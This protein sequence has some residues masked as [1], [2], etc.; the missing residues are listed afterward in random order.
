MT[1]L[2]SMTPLAW[3]KMDTIKRIICILPSSICCLR[4]NMS[5]DIHTTT[6]NRLSICAHTK[7]GWGPYGRT[8]V[9]KTLPAA[10]EAPELCVSSAE[11]TAVHLT[12]KEKHNNGAPVLDYSIEA[13]QVCRQVQ[14]DQE[15]VCCACD[16][17]KHP[18]YYLS[19]FEDHPV[20]EEEQKKS[21]LVGQEYFV[22]CSSLLS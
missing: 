9:L 3:L 22:C 18:D 14:K 21:I 5:I 20:I 2:S 11:G 8:V 6:I 17:H 7:K 15:G 16:V 19:P 4:G 13:I 1:I 12:I 10:P